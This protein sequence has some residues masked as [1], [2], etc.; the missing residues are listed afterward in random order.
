MIKTNSVRIDIKYDTT[1]EDVLG[2][3]KNVPK[4]ATVSVTKE[5]YYDQRDPGNTYITLTWREIL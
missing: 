2:A 3:L 1:A 5:K 4:H